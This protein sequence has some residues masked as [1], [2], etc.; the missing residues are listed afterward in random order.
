MAVAQVTV[1]H[2]YEIKT[3]KDEINCMKIAMKAMEDNIKFLTNE[4]KEQ[5][6]ADKEVEIIKK[7][8]SEDIK[9]QHNMTDVTES[10]KVNEKEN[11][12]LNCDICKHKLKTETS[13]A[14]HMKT[15][16]EG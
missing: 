6:R 1:K 14:K 4:L 5:C 9:E 10:G 2:E 3:L 7:F 13:L 11:S 15:K 12:I 16:H 8:V